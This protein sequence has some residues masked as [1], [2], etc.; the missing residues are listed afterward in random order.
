MAADL[1]RFENPRKSAPSA[2][3]GRILRGKIRRIRDAFNHFS[4]KQNY[5][6]LFKLETTLIFSDYY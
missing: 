6:V 1:F 3:L 5:P 2:F 4:L